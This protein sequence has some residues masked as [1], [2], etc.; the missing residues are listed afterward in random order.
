VDLLD[1]EEC[2]SSGVFERGIWA[3]VAVKLKSLATVVN[4]EGMW[5]G[6]DGGAVSLLR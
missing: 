5:P 1:E 6:R 3:R 4:P 2:L